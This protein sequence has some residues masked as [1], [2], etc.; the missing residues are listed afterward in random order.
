VWTVD[1]EVLVE[2]L[3]CGGEL[4]GAECVAS[5]HVF[6]YENLEI[7]WCCVIGS[8]ICWFALMCMCVWLYVGLYKMKVDEMDGETSW[9]DSRLETLCYRAE[10]EG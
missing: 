2:A 4:G 6:F 3:C 7:L 9:G 1:G 10:K 8:R 5:Y